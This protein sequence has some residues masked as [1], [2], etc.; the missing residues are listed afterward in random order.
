MSCI[1]LSMLINVLL[2]FSYRILYSDLCSNKHKV[3]NSKYVSKQA[4]NCECL[5]YLIKSILNM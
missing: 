4:I 5:T 3:Q 2:N 1:S